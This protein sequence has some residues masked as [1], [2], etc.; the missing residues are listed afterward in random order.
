MPLK[1]VATGD[2]PLVGP[3]RFSASEKE[4]AASVAEEKLEADVNGGSE[5]DAVTPLHEQAIAAWASYVLAT[6]P[7]EP[8]S[9][10]SGFNSGGAGDDQAEFASELKAIYE[11]NRR[12]ILKSEDDD[13][14]DSS[15]IIVN[16]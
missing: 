6:G 8:E 10:K 1:Y 15:E 14:E 5:F 13:S 9:S 16:G 4:R 11:D 7:V 12:S 3:D 2:I